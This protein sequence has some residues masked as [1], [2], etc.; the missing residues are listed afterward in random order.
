M[1]LVV[2]YSKTNEIQYLDKLSDEQIKDQ[3]LQV[4]NRSPNILGE[5]KYCMASLFSNYSNILGEYIEDGGSFMVSLQESLDGIVNGGYEDKLPNLTSGDRGS[6]IVVP[7]KTVNH[8]FSCVVYKKDDDNYECVVVNKGERPHDKNGK[9]KSHIKYTINKDKMDDIIDGCFYKDDVTMEEIYTT[10][11]KTKNK[12]T[13]YNINLTNQKTGNCYYKE[14]EAALKYSYYNY[15]GADEKDFANNKWPISN[16]EM[17]KK[18]LANIK[19]N[20]ATRSKELYEFVDNIERGYSKNKL[21]REAI[22]GHKDLKQEDFIQNFVKYFCDGNQDEMQKGIGQIDAQTL[23]EFPLF[24]KFFIQ[25]NQD[26][27]KEFPLKISKNVQELVADYQIKDVLVSKK[28]FDKF[29]DTYGKYFPTIVE[30]MRLEL[31]GILTKQEEMIYPDAN[32]KSDDA[33]KARERVKKICDVGLELN[34]DDVLSQYFRGLYYFDNGKFED[35]KEDFFK[36]SKINPNEQ[37]YKKIYIE[38]LARTGNKEYH[39]EI[40]TYCK[41]AEQEG[42]DDGYSDYIQGLKYFCSGNLNDA[43]KHFLKAHKI[44]PDEEE[45]AKLYEEVSLKID[46]DKQ[47][48]ITQKLTNTKERLQ[49]GILD[50]ITFEYSTKKINKEIDNFVD[51]STNKQQ[52]KKGREF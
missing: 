24:D 42:L 29:K 34:P 44:D 16:L 11:E 47:P 5:G 52:P 7:I 31:S 10:F 28:E 48:S 45:Y 41:E 25:Y 27:N 14:I 8:M 38:S 2:M 32:D 21:F 43:K 22:G 1:G 18:F 36:I 9:V 15:K 50:D 23:L 12:V 3:A 51:N 6:F 13:I 17:H 40:D 49:Q 35:A 37:E 33:D 46:G 20:I 30:E 4:V 19:E 26:Y 39:Q